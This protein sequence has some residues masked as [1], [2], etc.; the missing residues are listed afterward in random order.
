MRRGILDPRWGPE[1]P[2]SPGEVHSRRAVRR[3]LPE[4]VSA[5]GADVES[6][7]CQLTTETGQTRHSSQQ[8]A[9]IIN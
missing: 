9:A 6:E 2:P 7:A 3:E 8:R 4:K 1:A 5:K